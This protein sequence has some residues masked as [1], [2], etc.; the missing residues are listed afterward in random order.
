MACAATTVSCGF[1]STSYTAITTARRERRRH[2]RNHRAQQDASRPRQC[3][4]ERSALL[5]DWGAL[6]LVNL[7]I[8]VGAGDE[9]REGHHYAPRSSLEFLRSDLAEQVGD[10]G[11]PVVVSHHLHLHS[12]DYDWP[13]EDRAAYYET[14]SQYNVVAIFNGH[15]HGSPPRR[16]RWDGARLTRQALA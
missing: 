1:P 5:V 16:H 10:S 13:S 7:G 8:F 2:R 14:L 12:S 6:H 3:V 4:A 9:K 11:R 15:S